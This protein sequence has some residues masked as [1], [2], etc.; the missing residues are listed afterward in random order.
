MAMLKSHDRPEQILKTFFFI[1][2]S[3][4]LDFPD[5]KAPPKNTKKCRATINMK[6]FLTHMFAFAF[7]FYVHIFLNPFV[8]SVVDMPCTLKF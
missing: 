6:L 5:R 7:L 8:I 4:K 3:S 1:Y 2:M